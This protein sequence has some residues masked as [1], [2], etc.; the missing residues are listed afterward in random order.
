V[1][2][3]ETFVAAIRDQPADDTLRLVYADWLEDR[4][5][6]RAEFLRLECRLH[7]MQE[8]ATEFSE[9]QRQLGEL[10]SPLDVRW[11][12]AVC[13]VHAEYGSPHQ[14]PS[15]CPE[16]VSGAFYTC[17]SCLWCGAPETQAPEL[18]APLDA[19]NSITYF[20]RQPRTAV[21]IQNA[22]SAI[23]VC[24][25]LDLRYGGTD[26]LVIL[27]LGNVP[28]HCDNLIREGSPRLVP[29]PPRW[30]DEMR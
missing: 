9:L 8:T 26:P 5:D 15:R 21:E 18:L 6:S 25:V 10:G 17:G 2:D 28:E 4:G 1:A 24:C 3:D 13:R 7:G 22:C 12:A 23:V 11:L 19:D 20:V 30:R 14:H 27:R 16:T 29:A